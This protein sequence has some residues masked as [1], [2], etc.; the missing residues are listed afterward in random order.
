MGICPLCEPFSNNLSELTFIYITN[1]RAYQK[2]EPRYPCLITLFKHLIR[3]GI[4]TKSLRQ[5][6]LYKRDEISPYECCPFCSKFFKASYGMD[7]PIKSDFFKVAPARPPFHY[8]VIAQFGINKD[9]GA[10]FKKCCK[11]KGV[12]SNVRVFHLSGE[13]D[14]GKLVL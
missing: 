5:G 6:L 10:G 9:P 14:N 11:I 13:L 4:A 3:C 8:A 12:H 1:G 7:M 2:I